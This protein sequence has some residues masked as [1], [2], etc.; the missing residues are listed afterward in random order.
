MKYML[1][2]A[3]T[4]CL[5]CGAWAQ[6]REHADVSIVLRL[7]APPA[8]VFPLFGPVRESEWAPHWNPTI[9]Y[10][11]DKSQIAGTVFTTRQHNQDVI[12]ML[13]TYDEAALRIVYVQLWPDMCVTK[14]EIALKAIDNQTEATVMHRM[15]SL[16]EH[17]DEFVKQFSAHFPSERDHWEQAISGRLRELTRH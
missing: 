2:A 6:T 11:L 8:V 14:L 13:E 15:T 4:L 12:W 5:A 17:G 7:P 10:P 1:A 16:S 3:L 9:L